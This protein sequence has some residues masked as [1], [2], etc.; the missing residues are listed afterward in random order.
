MQVRLRRTLS[1]AYEAFGSAGCTELGGITI[2]CMLGMIVSIL[3]TESGDQRL[4]LAYG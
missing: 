1:M 2:L 3:V 4:L